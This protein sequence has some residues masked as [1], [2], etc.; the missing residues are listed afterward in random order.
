MRTSIRSHIYSSHMCLS[1]C[2]YCACYNIRELIVVPRFT[3]TFHAYSLVVFLYLYFYLCTKINLSKIECV[4]LGL[5][6][7]RRSAASECDVRAKIVLSC[8]PSIHTPCL[9]NPLSSAH[10]RGHRKP[11]HN[12]RCEQCTHT[13]TQDVVVLKH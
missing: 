3:Y 13:E 7:T 10:P 9:L 4:T 2:A 8:V 5:C 1:V 11:T 12:A 6:F